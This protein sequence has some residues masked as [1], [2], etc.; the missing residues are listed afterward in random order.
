MELRKKLIEFAEWREEAIIPDTIEELVDD[1]LQQ[2]EA[3]DIS[4]NAVLADSLPPSELISLKEYYD[5]KWMGG[6]SNGGCRTQENVD[7]QKISKDIEKRLAEMA[8]NFR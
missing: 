3:K 7:A 1:F 6:S 2:T 5:K 4:S 8:V